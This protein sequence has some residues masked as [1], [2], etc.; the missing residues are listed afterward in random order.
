MINTKTVMHRNVS[1]RSLFVLLAAV[2]L[3]LCFCINVQA[4]PEKTVYASNLSEGLWDFPYNEEI[5]LNIV[6][7]KDCTID[8]IWIHFSDW[9]YEGD[10]KIIGNGYKLLVGNRGIEVNQSNLVIEDAVIEIDTSEK[11]NDRYYGGIYVGK[12]LTI[13]RSNIEIHN[14]PVLPAINSGHTYTDENASITGYE[15]EKYYSIRSYHPIDYV[16]VKVTEPK[17]GE[18]AVFKGSV[19]DNDSRN[20]Q[21]TVGTLDDEKIRWFED[22]FQ[23]TIWAFQDL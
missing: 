3:S 7:D 2:V 17:C 1:I 21:L 22:A 18:K 19:D 10:V 4:K 13:T 14:N 5:S 11:Y 6:L 9:E 12:F 15:F 20:I 16:N 23:K 8:G